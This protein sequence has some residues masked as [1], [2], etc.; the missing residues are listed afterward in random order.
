M[1]RRMR[2]LD[3]M[4]QEQKAI[5]T[6]IRNKAEEIWSF[7]G[8]ECFTIRTEMPGWETL[9]DFARRSLQRER[10]CGYVRINRRLF[11]ELDYGGL[12]TYVPVHGGI[13]YRAHDHEG[14]MI[15]GFDCNH[16][17]DE[18]REFTT[19]WVKRET[20]ALATGLLVAVR[21]E[22]AYLARASVGTGKVPKW[23]RRRRRKQLRARARIIDRFH[24]ALRACGGPRFD[25]QDNF[26]AMIN[27]LGG[28][29]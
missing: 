8:V 6:S 20:E 15:Y 28:R 5:P 10:P 7:K 26:G 14:C 3:R 24:Q 13:S 17:G 11:R 1:A 16:A 23:R 12:L 22:A 27:L 29:L 21:F 25:L 19:E 9:P 4:M 18:Q 2:E